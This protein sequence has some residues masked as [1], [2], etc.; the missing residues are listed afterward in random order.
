[1]IYQY[2]QDVYKF[3]LYLYNTNKMRA[4]GLLVHV[5]VACVVST[6]VSNYT[7]DGNK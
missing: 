1:M 7:Y 5:F 6:N 2:N 4:N 3:I